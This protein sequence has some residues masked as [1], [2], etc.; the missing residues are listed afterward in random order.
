MLQLRDS[1]VWDSWFAFD[2][3]RHHA[4]YLRAS[5][6]LGDPNRRHRHPFI[7]HA[8]STDLK[9]WEVVSDAIAIGD[10]P[11]WDSWTTWT[12]SVTRDDDGLWWMF[13]T[14]TSREDGGDVQRVGAAT[15]KDLMVWTKIEANPLTEADPEFYEKLDYDLWHD[16]AWR[17][18][19][20]FRHEGTWHMI[21]TARG[22][23]GSRHGRGVAGHAVSEDLKTWKVLPP[24][25]ECESGFGQM[26]VIQISEIE[27]IPTMVWCCGP[28]ELSP[29]MREKYPSGGMF[30]TTGPS[31]LGPFNPNEAV[32]FPHETLYAARAVQ[33]EGSW[34]MIGFIAGPD[35]DF[36][37]YLCDPIPLVNS[38]RGVLPAVVLATR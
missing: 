35:K 3:E 33:H 5:R 38:G 14:G 15:S 26:E 19:W 37:G 9:N 27:G 12:G 34:Y 2:G 23:E 32:W 20:V 10:A 7:G 28:N 17:D 30:S 18:P 36:G 31:M 25:T 21:V 1:W 4:F 16:E 22:L 8:V 13:F 6:A 24:L 11:A 29:E